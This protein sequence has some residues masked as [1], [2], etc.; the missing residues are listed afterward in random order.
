MSASEVAKTVALSVVFAAGAAGGIAMLVKRYVW[1]ALERLVG[2]YSAHTAQRLAA[3]S[4]FTSGV[5]GL[6]RLY[7]PSDATGGP[8]AP[9]TAAA[10]SGSTSA[11]GA[12]AGDGSATVV[13]ALK[14]AIADST[15]RTGELS[16]AVEGLRGRRAAT[17]TGREARVLHAALDVSR[18]LSQELYASSAGVYSVYGRGLGLGG[19]GGERGAVDQLKSEIRSLKGML[20]SRRNFPTAPGA[21]RTAE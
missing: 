2:E 9:G 15:A 20:I 21:G 1:A 13:G 5:L 16:A 11:S 8:S 3:V 17:A 4:R 18:M 14:R 10:G 19:G 12:D 7:E 6:C